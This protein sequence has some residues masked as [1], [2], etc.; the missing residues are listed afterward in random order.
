MDLTTL[1][2]GP[3]WVLSALSGTG[4]RFSPREQSVFWDILVE[5]ALRTPEPA[6]SILTS[7]TEDRTGLLLVFELDDRP[8]VSGFAAVVR[9]LADVPE[10]TA[11]DYKVALLR[12]GTGLGRARGPYGETISGTDIQLL[13]LVAELLDLRSPSVAGE[14]LV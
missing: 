1:Q 2:L 8:L 7:L 9:A 10:E 12:V 13:L 4:S 3:L 5:V 14:A 6:R 11:L